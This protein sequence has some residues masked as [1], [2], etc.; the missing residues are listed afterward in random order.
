[1]ALEEC[2]TACSKVKPRLMIV[3]LSVTVFS[4]PTVLFLQAPYKGLGLGSRIRTD[5]H[6]CTQHG[7]VTVMCWERSDGHYLIVLLSYLD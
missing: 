3:S 5:T 7:H 2:R 1:M 4:F 6:T